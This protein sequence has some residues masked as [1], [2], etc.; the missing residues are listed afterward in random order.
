MAYRPVPDTDY[1]EFPPAATPGSPG[2]G[3]SVVADFAG[4]HAP[5]RCL[6]LHPSRRARCVPPCA[7]TPT[8]PSNRTPQATPP[9]PRCLP[10]P[11]GTSAMH[12][13][14]PRTPGS[15]PAPAP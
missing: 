8:V 15:A 10:R 6:Y 9:A 7:R 5:Q 14:C 2:R 11:A 13:A 3:H 4:Q 12:T 1:H